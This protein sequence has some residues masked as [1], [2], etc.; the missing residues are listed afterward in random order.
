MMIVAVTEDLVVGASVEVLATVPALPNHAAAVVR[1]GCTYAEW[2]ASAVVLG[3]DP[4]AL[5][6]ELSAM[7][8]LSIGPVTFVEVELV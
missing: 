8:F 7:Q 1:V 3:L 6:R 2:L 4:Q 5:E